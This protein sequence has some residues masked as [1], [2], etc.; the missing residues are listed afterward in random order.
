M[1]FFYKSHLGGLCKH[2]GGTQSWA[3]TALLL[4]QCTMEIVMCESYHSQTVFSSINMHVFR[5]I[6]TLKKSL[7]ENAPLTTV[8]RIIDSP[9]SKRHFYN[10]RFQYQL[11]IEH[12]RL[13]NIVSGSG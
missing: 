11:L 6:A 4:T 13:L 10:R 7:K 1:T 2:F 8:I 5:T 3:D 9:E 12:K